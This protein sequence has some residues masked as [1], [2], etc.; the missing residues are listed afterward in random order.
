MNNSNAGE[1]NPEEEDVAAIKNVFSLN[2][3]W[4]D[5]HLQCYYDDHQEKR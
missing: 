5:C 3:I 2:K 4:D 1:D